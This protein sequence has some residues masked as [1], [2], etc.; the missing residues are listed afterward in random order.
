MRADGGKVA[1]VGCGAGWSSIILAREYPEAR[2]DGFDV[3]PCSVADAKAN[4]EAAGVADRV[5]I[6]VRD[7]ADPALSGTYDLVCVFDSLHDM[8]RPVEVLRSCRRLR[9]DGGSVLLLEPKAAHAYT[10]P[11]DEVERFLYAV[12][13]LHCLPVGMSEQPSA[14]TGTLLRPDTLRDYARAA[15]FTDVEILPVQHRFHRLYHA[16]G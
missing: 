10:A 4:A 14:S 7:A 5:D 12:S 6:Q 3:D 8:P 13:V 15:G 11:G 1:D 9:A 16:V 2:V